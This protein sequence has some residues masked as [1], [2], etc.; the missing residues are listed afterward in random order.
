MPKLWQIPPVSNTK[1]DATELSQYGVHLD[2]I[3]S[4]CHFILGREQSGDGHGAF[5]HTRFAITKLD[6]RMTLP[7]TDALLA[8]QQT[9]YGSLGRAATGVNT[10]DI[11]RRVAQYS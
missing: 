3:G 7:A 8:Q 9:D 5:H 4:Q 2:E 10:K 1:W 11:G 6:I